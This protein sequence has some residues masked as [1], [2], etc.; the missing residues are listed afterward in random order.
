MEIAEIL[1]DRSKANKYFGSGS[2]S[3]VN[4]LSSSRRAIPR[5]WGCS[6]PTLLPARE[7]GFS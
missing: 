6:H 2:S 7:F 4:N 3:E 1:R 5:R